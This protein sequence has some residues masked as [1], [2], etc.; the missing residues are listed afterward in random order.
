[1]PKRIVKNGKKERPAFRLVFI[2]LQEL[3]RVGSPDDPQISAE[4][5]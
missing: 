2:Y 1:M 5:E 3:T 4:R